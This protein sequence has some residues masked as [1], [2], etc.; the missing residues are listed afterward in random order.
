MME[1][2]NNLKFWS[3]YFCSVI[4]IRATFLAKQKII[5]QT[6]K[7]K[8]MKKIKIASV[9]FMLFATL[10]AF[11]NTGNNEN[12]EKSLSSQIYEMLEENPFQILSS[13]LTA[14]VR[15]TINNKGELVVLSV[16]TKNE[17]L[18]K[19]VKSRLNYK[20]VEAGSIV[21]GRIYTVPVRITA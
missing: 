14:D 21:E 2:C 3:S 9:A 8:I 6:S 16:D 7:N 18:E 1:K 15:F 13:E 17:V 19:F 12:P 4:K 11:A 5:H 20:K 10:G